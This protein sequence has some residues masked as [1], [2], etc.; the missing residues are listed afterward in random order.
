MVLAPVRFYIIVT[1]IDTRE[2][3]MPK[4]SILVRA[5]WDPDAGVWFAMSDDVP[6]LV[7]EAATLEELERKLHV[8][9]PELLEFDEELRADFLPEVPLIVMSQQVSKVRLRA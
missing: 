8:M 6:G 2:Q 5:E 9:I 1:C 3:A 7:T 4:A